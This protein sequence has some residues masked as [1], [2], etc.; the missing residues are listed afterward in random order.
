MIR[1]QTGRLNGISSN[2]QSS[3]HSAMTLKQLKTLRI[4]SI[5]RKPETVEGESTGQ[6]R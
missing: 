5:T 2:S 3:K 1:T 6:H 4:L